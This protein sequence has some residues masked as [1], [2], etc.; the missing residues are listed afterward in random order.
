MRAMKLDSTGILISLRPFGERDLIAHIFTYEHGIISGMM[1]GAAIARKNKPL[2]GQVGVATWNARLESQLGTFH[3]DAEKNLAAPLML[4]AERLSFMNAAL[5]LLYALLPERA[6]YDELYN[7]TIDLL[8]QMATDNPR[9]A[10]LAWEINLLRE[11]GYALDTTHCAACGG[12]N[13]LNYLSPRTGRAVCNGCAAPYISKLY[14]LP[15]NL[16]V[17]LRF[18]DSVCTGQGCTLPLSR[19]IIKNTI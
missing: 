14:K 3:W 9:D 8:T 13:N 11:L 5:D 16:N 17:T 18:I 15:L 7:E 10:Y 2:V 1:R 6:Q 4:D 19:R 12:V